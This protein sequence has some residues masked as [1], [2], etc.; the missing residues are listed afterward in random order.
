MEPSEKDNLNIEPSAH[1]ETSPADGDGSLESIQPSESLD[2]FDSALPSD[3]TLIDNDGTSSLL[4]LESLDSMDTLDGIDPLKPLDPIDLPKAAPKADRPKLRLEPIAPPIDDQPRDER[5]KPAQVAV[6]YGLLS[7]VG[8]FEYKGDQRLLLDQPV[9]IETERG[10]ELGRTVCYLNG[11]EDTH[12]VSSTALKTY[13]K[14]SGDGTL[15]HRAGRIVRTATCQDIR[16]NEHLR[17][18]ALPKRRYCQQMADRINLKMKIVCAEHV[19]GGERIVFYFTAEG[20]IDFRELVRELAREYQ[21]RIELR[22]IGARD[23]AR[24][25]AD[26]EIC[27]RQCCCKNFLKVLRPVNM[28]MAKLQKATLDPS[29]VSGRCGRLR[30]C[31]AYE[32]R[33]YEELSAKLPRVGLYVQTPQGPGRVR[34]RQVLTQLVQVILENNRI[35]AF[36]LEEITP[37]AAPPAGARRE[38]DRPLRDTRDTRPEREDRRERHGDVDADGDEDT[39][40]DMIMPTDDQEGDIEAPAMR[41]EP[42]DLGEDSERHGDVDVETDDEGGDDAGDNTPT[43]VPQRDDRQVRPEGTGGN[44]GERRRRRRGRR[45]R[46]RPG[47]EGAPNADGQRPS[48]SENRND[49]RPPR[50]DDRPP[51]RDSNN[52]S[53]N[54]GPRNDAP[55]A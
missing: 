26:Y 28:K 6:R 36:G 40:I 53:G 3:D 33:C 46:R 11:P 52:S 10:L 42:R 21:T 2:A 13:L 32:H 54:S 15:H 47:G 23:E 5:R 51:R 37:M 9:L 4:P 20:R 49:N 7:F 48:N 45:S 19:F 50:R 35:V 55:P 41:P 34:E 22:Q 29:K 8:E 24:L 43:D 16:E 12:H 39:P 18:D 44:D 17:H 14:N 31:L 38:G 27:G 25:L 1:D 30:C